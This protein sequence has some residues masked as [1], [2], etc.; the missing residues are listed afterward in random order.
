MATRSSVSKPCSQLPGELITAASC[1]TNSL[2]P[3][4][5]VIHQAFSIRH[6]GL[7]AAGAEQ[8]GSRVMTE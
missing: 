3:L 6:G 7:A 4:V 8:R 5:D 1:T 2:A